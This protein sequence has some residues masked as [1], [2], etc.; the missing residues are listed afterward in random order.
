MK[1]KGFFM[2]KTRR[3]DEESGLRTLIR[4]LDLAII[5]VLGGVV[6][7]YFVTYTLPGAAG[8]SFAWIVMA[9]LIALVVALVGGFYWQEAEIDLLK[10]QALAIVNDSRRT[11]R[12]DPTR[13]DDLLKG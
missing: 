9:G 11:D 4:P 6:V 3:S 12:Q 8:G 2:L 7:S 10:R 13:D 1:L 5:A